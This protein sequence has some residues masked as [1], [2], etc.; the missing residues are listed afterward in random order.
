VNPH[1]SLTGL[2]SAGAAQAD[3]PVQQRAFLDALR[4]AVAQGEASPA[5]LAV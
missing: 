2:L 5:D 4:G 1:S 3:D